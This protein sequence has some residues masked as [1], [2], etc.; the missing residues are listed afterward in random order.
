MRRLYSLLLVVMAL[1]M[2]KGAWADEWETFVVDGIRYEKGQAKMAPNDGQW[3][4]VSYTVTVGGRFGSGP[5]VSTETTGTVTIPESVTAPDGL[6]CKVVYI[7]KNAF[8]KCKNINSIILPGTIEGIGDVA[9]GGCESLASVN[10]PDAVTSIGM[11]VFDGCTS[12]KSLTLP[13]GLQSIGS[14]AFDNCTSLESITIPSSVTSIGGNPV[15]GCSALS[16]IIVES[17]NTVYDSRNNCNAIISTSDNKLIAGCQNTIIPNGI[18][19]IGSYAFSGCTGLT[20]LSIPSTVTNIGSSAFRKCTGLTSINIPNSVGTIGAF[21]F[22]GCSALVSVGLPNS[23]TSIGRDTF[24]GCSNLSSIVIPSTV[25]SIGEFAFFGCKSIPSLVIPKSVIQIGNYAFRYMESCNA[26]TVEDGNPVFDSRNN[27][28]AIINTSTNELV[29]GCTAT[30]IPETVTAIGP[31]AFCGAGIVNM[32]IP[33]SVTSIGESVFAYCTS[34]ESV[35][36]P[37]GLKELAKEAFHGCSSLKAIDIPSSVEAVMNYAVYECGSLKSVIIPSKVSSIGYCAFALCP[38]LVEITSYIEEPNALGTV[39]SDYTY[40]GATLIV[41]FGTKAKYMAATGWKKFQNI[42]E[43]GTLE[44]IQGET[45]VATDG[46]GSEDLSDNVVN[47]VYYNVGSEGYDSSDQSIV[48]NQPTNMSQISDATPGSNDV[49]NN[50]TGLILKVAAGKGL[51][52]VNAKTTGNAQL[53]VQV[54]SQ[55]PMIATKTEQGD[56]IVSYDVAEDTFV[57]IYAIIGS[58]TAPAL[59]AAGTDVVKIYA[60]T[61]TPGGTGIDLTTTLPQGEGVYYTLDGR[62]VFGKPTQKGLYIR[63]GRKVVMK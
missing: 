5:A 40:N 15:A 13:S 6:P 17:G 33:N 57:Y 14:N 29:A 26:I 58:S 48:I 42:K 62:K 61:V 59:R 49:K 51:I 54:G 45:T 34:L 18:I 10:I 8:E 52:K 1:M 21:A 27:C 38:N 23:I 35:V 24:N 53:V 46:L 36:L 2:P 43:I 41:P 20:S 25:T 12:L 37:D 11:R 39:F 16:S 60:I 30:I 63:N 44:P 9:F 47:D 3:V 28:N 31:G 19:T 32:E 50:F 55:T 22:D 4:T 7:F 56:V